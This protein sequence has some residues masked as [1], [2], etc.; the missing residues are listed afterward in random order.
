MPE[1]PKGPDGLNGFERA[2]LKAL[3]D[4]WDDNFEVITWKLTADHYYRSQGNKEEHQQTLEFAVNTFWDRLRVLTL[5]AED[6]H[7]ISRARMEVL[8]ATI[9]NWLDAYMNDRVVRIDEVDDA[10]AA[11]EGD[12]NFIQ[13][14]DFLSVTDAGLERHTIFFAQAVRGSE[15]Y[16]KLQAGDASELY[17]QPP[18]DLALA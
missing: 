10:L 17:G 18:E 11:I 8:A 15:I 9:L 5:H 2:H 6:K 14:E 1:F 3:R 12:P 4:I 16:R 13:L 7:P